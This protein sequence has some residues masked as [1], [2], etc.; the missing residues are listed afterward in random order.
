M[1]AAQQAGELENKCRR[2]VSIFWRWCVE[3]G[4]EWHQGASATI[5]SSKQ[6]KYYDESSPVVS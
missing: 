3:A 4:M 6:Y 1:Y 2:A 5:G